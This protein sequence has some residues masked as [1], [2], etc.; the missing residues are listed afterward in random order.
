LVQVAVKNVMSGSKII[1]CDL[2]I[3]DQSPV[4]NKEFTIHNLKPG[5]LVSA[6]VSKVLENGIELSFL[7]GFNGTV[8]VDHLD[9]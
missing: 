9:R 6:K 3:K 8:F 1:K 2:S 7:G 5:F 4:S